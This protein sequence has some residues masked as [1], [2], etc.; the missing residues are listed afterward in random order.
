LK[1]H[2][3]L[4]P[5]F[6]FLNHGTFG[7]CPRPVLQAQ[8]DLRHRMEAN[9][10]RFFEGELPALLDDAREQL[11]DF[12]GAHRAEDLAFLPNVTSGVNTVLRSLLFAPGDELLITNHRYKAVDTAIDFVAQRS[13]AIKRVV[14]VP[15]PIHEPDA[16]LEAVLGA[17]NARTRLVII[18][19]VTSPTGLVFPIERLVAELSERGVDTL[20]DGAHAVGMLPLQLEKLGAAYYTGNCHKWLCAPKGSAFLWVRSDRQEGLSPLSISGAKSPFYHPNRFRLEFGWTGTIDPSPYLCVPTAIRTLKNL[21]EG[22]WPALR[23]HNHALVL[24][25]RRL[26]CEALGNSPAAPD[27]MIGSLAT[28]ILPDSEHTV[29]SPTQVDALEASLSADYGIDVPVFNFSKSPRRLL[30]VSAQIYNTEEEYSRLVAA[31]RE[32]LP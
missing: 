32:L 12:I 18:D 21:V 16:V 24:G 3:A 2:W 28:I 29:Q 27:S 22:G 9:P 31:L 17:V 25:A 8:T 10:V 20:V 4:Q 23:A 30:R 26:L 6:T 14:D 7:A 13:G 5:G 1:S 15:F 11:A 19:H